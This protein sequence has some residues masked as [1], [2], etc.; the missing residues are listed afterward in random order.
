M[1][2]EEVNPANGTLAKLNTCLKSFQDEIE[3]SM[4][5]FREKVNKLEETNLLFK[6]NL[7]SKVT[8]SE[9]MKQSAICTTL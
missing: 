7:L 5:D 9:I 1:T 6:S 3:N 2:T 8:T 4:T